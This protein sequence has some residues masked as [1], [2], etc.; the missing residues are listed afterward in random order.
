MT[1][2]A[3]AP[4]ATVAAALADVATLG[5][6]FAPVVAGPD[7]GWHPVAESYA[8]GSADLVADNARRYGTTEPR[9]A[10]SV[11]QLGHAARLW[12][13]LLAC[14]VVHG[15]VPDP[16]DLQRADDGPAL[17]FPTPVG[18]WARDRG[19]T[20]A[21]LYRLV[22]EERLTAMAAGLRVRIAPRLLIGNAAS[23]LVEAGRA[24]V[25][26]RPGTR[27]AAGDLVARLLA[28]G[29]LVGTG[30]ITDSALSFRRR[31]CCLFYRV[32]PGDRC[33]DCSLDR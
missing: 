31:S 22:V 8:A 12:S 18:W 11:V 24:L 6:F 2:P 5:G 10:A 4:P 7:D 33:G 16:A 1:S 17:R 29:A 26:A 20:A 3:Q 23:A 21:L 32:P 30:E 15:V 19:E 28:T 25:A 13:P 14:A 9:V 27:E